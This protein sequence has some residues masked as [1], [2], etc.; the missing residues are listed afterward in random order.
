M[1]SML[2]FLLLILGVALIVRKN[3]VRKKYDVLMGFGAIL[4]AAGDAIFL[5]FFR[6]YHDKFV[7]HFHHL[8]IILLLTPLFLGSLIVIAITITK[9]IHKSPG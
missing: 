3:K 6:H 5:Y 8:G 2:A 1:L 4:T 7:S 9:L